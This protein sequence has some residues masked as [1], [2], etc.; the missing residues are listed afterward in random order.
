VTGQNEGWTS[1]LESM[2]LLDALMMR[3]VRS[4]KEFANLVQEESK[5]ELLYQ[6]YGYLGTARMQRVAKR[7]SI[8]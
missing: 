7:L 2:K 6:R 4:R 1:Y 5:W 8:K 3:N